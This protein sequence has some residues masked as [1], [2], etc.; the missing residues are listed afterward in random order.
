MS[1]HYGI[2]MEDINH[3]LDAILEGQEAMGYV[4]RDIDQL[5]TDMSE[6]RIDIK[7]IK[8]VMTNHDQRIT[9]LEKTAA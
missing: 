5:K 7:A 6:V 2:F 8:A 1:D 3:K 4:P 9:K